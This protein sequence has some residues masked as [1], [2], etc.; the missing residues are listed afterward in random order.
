MTSFL[1]FFTKVVVHV[2]YTP[3]S[4]QNKAFLAQKVRISHIF[5]CSK[6][7]SRTPK[8]LP[9]PSHA[10]IDSELSFDPEEAD[11]GLSV[12]F[13]DVSFEDEVHAQVLAGLAFEL[14]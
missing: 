7:V 8:K 9:P 6:P 14:E 1:L 10:S 2:L 12:A 13:E 3:L 4:G 11:E 5:P